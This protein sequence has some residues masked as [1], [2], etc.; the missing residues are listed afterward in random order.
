MADWQAGKIQTWVADPR[1]MSHGIDGIQ[2]GGRIAVWMTLT[3]SNES[4]IQTNARIVRT[5]QSQE[6]VIYRIVCPGTVDDAVAEALREK[7]NTQ[8]GLLNALKALQALRA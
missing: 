4:Y 7:S 2:K 5:G 6:S 3:W 1:S 8:S